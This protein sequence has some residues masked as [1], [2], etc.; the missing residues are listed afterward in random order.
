M[1]NCYNYTK[2]YYN[3]NTSDKQLFNKVAY[4]IFILK[5]ISVRL[6]YYKRGK[7]LVF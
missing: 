1:C 7:S 6:K 3:N 2:K 4:N 5:N